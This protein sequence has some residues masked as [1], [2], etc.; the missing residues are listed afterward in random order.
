MLNT[1]FD[2]AVNS[3]FKTKQDFDNDDFSINRRIYCKNCGTSLNDFL[4]TGFVGCA[5]CYETFRT[6]ALKLAEDIHGRGIHIGK[7][8]KGE[9]GKTAK[10]RELERLIRE[11][12]I[13]VLNE[14]YIKADELKMQIKRLREELK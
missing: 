11:K 7:V 10:R 2:N 1:P 9:S 5:Q 3:L 8:P 6:Y 4:D 13:A 12:E 14:N